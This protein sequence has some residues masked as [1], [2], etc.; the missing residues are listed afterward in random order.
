MDEQAHQDE[1]RQLGK[2]GILPDLPHGR[3]MPVRASKLSDVPEKLPPWRLVVQISGTSHTTLGLE[4]TE[5]ILVGR[6]DPDMER[7][8]ELD[9]TDYGGAKNGVSRRHAEIVFID[10][11][12][13]ISDLNSTN[14]T[15]LNGFLLPPNQSF[16]LRDGDELE[17][18]QM[19]LMIRFLRPPF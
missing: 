3:V 16:R 14:G 11:S 15:K 2:T 1:H 17:L 13:Y 5:R 12:L 10:N 19:K 7:Q 9:L 6:S 8:P 18:G 4:V